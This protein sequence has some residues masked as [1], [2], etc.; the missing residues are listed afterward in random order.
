MKYAYIKKDG[1]ITHKFVIRDLDKIKKDSY[2]EIFEVDSESELNAIE[3]YKE[4]YVP[5]EAEEIK[6]MIADEKNL[7]A[8]ESLKLKGELEEVD[9]KIKKK[10]KV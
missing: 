3:V 6:K 7:L 5:T 8:I 4:P 10:K 2:D 1:K 9:G